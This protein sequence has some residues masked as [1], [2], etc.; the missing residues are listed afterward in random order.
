MTSAIGTLVI[1]LLAVWIAA[2]LLYSGP[3]Q[4]ADQVTAVWA[5]GVTAA[6]LVLSSLV[7]LTV[8]AVQGRSRPVWLKFVRIAR[9]AAVVLGCAL[10]VI[11][12]LHYR[13]SAPRGEI[14]WV[15]VGAVVLAGA[16]LVHWWLRRAVRREIA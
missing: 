1:A 10:A 2:H 11:G 5:L 4:A 6:G 15:V 13:D 12:L 9:S 7:L 8:G 16:G 14:Y 3:G